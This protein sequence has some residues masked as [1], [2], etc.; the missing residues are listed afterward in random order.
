MTSQH[1]NFDGLVLR[2]TPRKIPLFFSSKWKD[3]P[4]TIKK[5]LVQKKNNNNYNN[6]NNNQ[7][8]QQFGVM[9]G[10][11]SVGPGGNFLSFDEGF[12]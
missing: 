7:Q 12:V 5:Q 6:N 4:T 10:N 9:G 11:P 3:V 1:V 2:L 8:Q